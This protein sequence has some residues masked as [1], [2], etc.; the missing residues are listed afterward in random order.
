M[1]NVAIKVL[2][3]LF[4]EVFYLV[5][6]DSKYYTINI[7]VCFIKADNINVSPFLVRF[8]LSFPIIPQIN[9]RVFWITLYTTTFSL[10]YIP[11]IIHRP[12][13]RSDK[14]VTDV[15][16]IIFH[17][18][19]LI[20]FLKNTTNEKRDDW[21]SRS[22]QKLRKKART[23]GLGGVCE[24]GRRTKEVLLTCKHPRENSTYFWDALPLQKKKGKVH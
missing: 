7:W 22:R 19:W 14:V 1:G 21:K 20:P 3:A 13:T 5:Q 2:M 23:W 8:I 16:G 11:S 9:S 15:K 6:L 12:G 24:S 17:H 4:T 10:P 18:F